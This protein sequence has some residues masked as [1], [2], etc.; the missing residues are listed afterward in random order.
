MACMRQEPASAPCADAPQTHAP[1]AHAPS[2]VIAPCVPHVRPQRGA[3]GAPFSPQPGRCRP[4]AHRDRLWRLGRPG[5]RQARRHL[6]PGRRGRRRQGRD[7]GGPR[8]QAQGSRDRRRPL[9]GRRIVPSPDGWLRPAA[10]RR[11]GQEVRVQ[12]ISEAQIEVHGLYPT[13]TAVA[14]RA[15]FLR[16][17]HAARSLDRG[18]AGASQSSRLDQGART[19]S[20]PGRWAGAE[21]S[22]SRWRVRRACR[23]RRPRPRPCR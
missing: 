23:S 5:E 8:A 9:E 18:S 10:L 13:L 22:R 14:R 6:L 4:D 3:D 11:H 20:L 12:V 1:R 2:G 7:P 16:S 17:P 15:G 21:A 19:S